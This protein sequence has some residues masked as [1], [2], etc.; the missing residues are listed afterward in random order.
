MLPQVRVSERLHAWRCYRNN[1]LC[2]VEDVR[3]RFVVWILWSE[4][5]KRN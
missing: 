3:R 1:S 2:Y 4:L 5:V